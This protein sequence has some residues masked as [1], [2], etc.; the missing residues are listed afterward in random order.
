MSD[1]NHPITRVLLDTSIVRGVV[2]GDANAKPL[3]LVDPAASGLSIALANNVVPE[4][5]LALYEGRVA[6]LDWAARIHLIDRLLDPTW[7]IFPNEAE[8]MILGELSPMRPARKVDGPH[9]RAIWAL[10]RDATKSEDLET[11]R[12]FLRSD[13]IEYQIKS[14]NLL[15]DA[16]AEEHRDAWRDMIGAVQ[17]Q[18]VGHRPSQDHI[19]EL[20]FKELFGGRSDERQLRQR[21]DGYIR[22]HSRFV[23]LALSTGSPYNPRS[24]NR[25]GDSFDLEML[26]ALAVPALICTVDGRLHTHIV[27]S[28][29]KQASQVL[30]PEE[31][32]LGSQR[33]D[34]SSRL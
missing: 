4:I 7:P 12:P 33:Q 13:G 2:H 23:Q 31:F 10:L 3:T 6:W 21:H 27:A 30:N 26:Q 18:I 5:L 17:A 29:S 20:L 24:P 9:T 28:G 25:R 22:S 14:S 8:M 15:A 32:L 1:T 16:R 11:G 34:L 19:V